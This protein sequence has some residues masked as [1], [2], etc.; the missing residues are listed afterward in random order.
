MP[1]AT[2]PHESALALGLSLV[3]PA[4]VVVTP[5]RVSSQAKMTALIQFALKHLSVSPFRHPTSDTR[6]PRA[7]PGIS[8]DPVNAPL[9]IHSF[10]PAAPVPSS[11][12]PTTSTPLLATALPPEP[13][14]LPTSTRAA[15]SSSPSVLPKLVSVVEII[16]R[17]FALPPLAMDAPGRLDTSDGKG[18]GKEREVETLADP[19]STAGGTQP[20]AKSLGKTVAGLHQYSRLGAL[21]ELGLAGLDVDGD[22]SDAAEENR[23][24]EIALNW[25]E[26]GGG[27][28]KRFAQPPRYSYQRLT[29][30]ISTGQKELIVRTWSSSSPRARYPCW[31]SLASRCVLLALRSYLE[32]LLTIPGALADISH[33]ARFRRTLPIGHWTRRMVTERDSP[34]RRSANASRKPLRQSQRRRLHRW[35]SPP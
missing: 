19:A 11:S 10:A 15:G 29:P 35:T 17:S 24:T 7:H 26:S 13:D 8:Q 23:Q 14:S 18:K 2:A 21:E 6:T 12:R 4:E 16:K 3:L 32:T 31:P 34:R 1:S 9:A 22:A 25:I 27:G 33:R 30:L 20:A 28:T 5:L